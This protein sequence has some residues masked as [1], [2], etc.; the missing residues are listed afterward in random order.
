M[1]IHKEVFVYSNKYE[2]LTNY[3]ILTKF[4]NVWEKR[5]K[6]VLRFT[7]NKETTLKF[8]LNKR[9]EEYIRLLTDIGIII[10]F[11]EHLLK[12]MEEVR[13]NYKTL[14]E[15]FMDDTTRGKCYSMSV[16]LSTLFDEFT[17]NKG[18]INLPLVSVEHQ[19]LE[20]DNK[21]Y[22]TTMHLIFPKDYYYNIYMPNNVRKL[23]QE[24]I[25][26]IKN[27]ILNNITVKKTI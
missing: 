25:D 18:T 5:I 12:R 27:D 7:K 11:P 15:H 26:E 20:H 2:N 19:W 16:A 9:Y 13:V 24:E 17:L 22:D 3:E 10:E 6:H 1:D 8:L 21:V 4:N 14:K 23:T